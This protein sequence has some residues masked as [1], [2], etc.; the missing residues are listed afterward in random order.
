MDDEFVSLAQQRFDDFGQRALEAMSRD[1]ARQLDVELAPLVASG[2][3][4][5]H[6]HCPALGVDRY[7]VDGRLRLEVGAVTSKQDGARTV[8]LRACTRYA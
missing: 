4:L 1:F 5:T 3:V 6:R 7:Y 8:V 2:G